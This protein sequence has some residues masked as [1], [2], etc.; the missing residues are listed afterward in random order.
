M[1]EVVDPRTHA[2]GEGCSLSNTLLS[3]LQSA[4]SSLPCTNVTTGM[5]L[6]MNFRVFILMAYWRIVYFVSVSRCAMGL[7]GAADTGHHLN[8][9]KTG[10]FEG[11][12]RSCMI[13]KGYFFDKCRRASTQFLLM[14][15]PSQAR[16]TAAQ[17]MQPPP[18]DQQ[19]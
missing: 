4:Y 5:G 7:S 15:T 6:L 18:T 3:L 9:D 2:K 12:R 11:L 16:P 19:Q 8:K 10:S 17:P 13:S 1:F 14:Q